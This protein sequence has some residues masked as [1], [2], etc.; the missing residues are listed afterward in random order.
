[1]APLRPGEAAATDF[2][3][4]DV[5]R[6]LRAVHE[7]IAD[8]SDVNVPSALK[9]RRRATLQ[10]VRLVFS[11]GLLRQND[12]QVPERCFHWALAIAHGAT[13]SIQF[14]DDVTHVISPR[15][16]TSSVQKAKARQL[17]AVT[18]QWL[19]DSAAQ[20]RRLPEAYY[21]L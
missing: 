16:D 18:P 21:V 11:G 17:H 7:G 13:C 12:V 4:Q 19:T 14:T 3:L 8:G 10:G 1:M 9:R 15:A 6:M 20:W 2:V 5:M